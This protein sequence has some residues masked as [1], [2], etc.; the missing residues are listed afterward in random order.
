MA[1][2]LTQ[3]PGMGMLTGQQGKCSAVGIGVLS[4][5]RR[6]PPALL[7]GRCHIRSMD[8]TYGRAY[9][10]TSGCAVPQDG[11]ANPMRPATRDWRPSG[12]GN[13]NL[14]IPVMNGSNNHTPNS[15]LIAR[16]M[17]PL[18]DCDLSDPEI[19]QLEV[20]A[21]R[22]AKVRR[23]AAWYEAWDHYRR[24]SLR[25]DLMCLL[26][27]AKTSGLDGFEHIPVDDFWAMREALRAE[28]DRLMRVPAPTVWAMREKHRLRR[29]AQDA[30]QAEEWAALV[31]ADAER[32]GVKCPVSKAS[33]KGGGA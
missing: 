26:R 10:S 28:V 12:R 19:G 13:L 18:P 1:D 22:D 5:L 9:G 29:A 17:Q 16:L 20:R 4:S 32:L 8:R 25:F 23:K 3:A 30:A 2:V 11:N 7:R 21:A 24:A 27:Q 14:R 15:D 31:A 33:G 6:L